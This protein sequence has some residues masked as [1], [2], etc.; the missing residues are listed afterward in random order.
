MSTATNR[1]RDRPASAYWRDNFCAQPCAVIP[2]KVPTT[3]TPRVAK[4]KPSVVVTAVPDRGLSTAHT[5]A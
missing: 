1:R 4:S 3:E 2:L 5:A